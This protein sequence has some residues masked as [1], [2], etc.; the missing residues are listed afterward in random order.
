MYDI[1]LSSGCR[2]RPNL[3]TLA[4]NPVLQKALHSRLQQP[5]PGFLGLNLSGDRAASLLEQLILAEGY[6]YVVPTAYHQPK[7]TIEMATPIAEQAITGKQ[8]SHFPTY[9]FEAVRF[10]REGTMWWEFVA[11]SEELIE[12]GHC[13]GAVHAL[14]DKLDG[15]VW[16]AGEEARLYA[17]GEE[18]YLESATTLSPEQVLHLLADVGAA[19]KAPLLEWGTDYMHENQTCLKGPALVISAVAHPFPAFIEN[20]HGFRP[21]V[22][23][24]FRIIPYK[25]GYESAT[26]LMLRAVIR[27]LRHDSRDAVLTTDAGD[28]LT[29]LHS[30][31]GQL[32]RGTEWDSWAGTVLTKVTRSYETHETHDLQNG[33]DRW[34]GQA[35]WKAGKRRREADSRAT[36]SLPFKEPALVT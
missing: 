23:V 6:G 32:V 5:E 14:V 24:Y 27:L 30:K 33:G 11:R 19:R 22:H 18:Y 12:E 9:T 3:S 2:R 15:H 26:L 10:L 28:L 4:D 16:S 1:Y 35:L 17:H 25:S 7:V 8:E 34:N 31:A 21:T 13:P 29:L 36:T 20:T